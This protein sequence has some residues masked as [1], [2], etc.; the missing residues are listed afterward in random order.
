[1]ALLSGCGGRQPSDLYSPESPFFLEACPT[2][3]SDLDQTT[4]S[5]AAIL[6]TLR[7]FDWIVDSVDAGA[8]EICASACLRAGD[9]SSECVSMVFAVDGGGAVI[10]TADPERPIVREMIGHAERWMRNLEQRFSTY[11]CM[12]RPLAMEQLANHGIR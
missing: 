4:R 7:D 5:F 12:I 10:A 1:M 3:L 6:R 2:S 8:G 11:R 9:Q